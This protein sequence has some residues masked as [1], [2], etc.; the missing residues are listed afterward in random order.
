MSSPSP[1]PE[2]PIP[3]DEVAAADMPLTMSASV[4]L[5]S[6]PKDAHEAL[7]NADDMQG[8]KGTDQ[9]PSSRSDHP[10]YLSSHIDSL[11]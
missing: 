6:L 7:D 11:I 3:D 5:S 8:K 2:G 4:V 1:G 10:E 9:N